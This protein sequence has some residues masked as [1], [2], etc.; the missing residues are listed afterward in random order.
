MPNRNGAA[1][2]S[3]HVLYAS[4][5]Y[6]WTFVAEMICIIEWNYEEHQEN[7]VKSVRKLLL[8]PRKILLGHVDVV[9]V[10]SCSA[11]IKCYYVKKFDVIG[12]RVVFL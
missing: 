5:V 9:K 3:N 11:V 8:R 7:N 2:F 4:F 6:P 1:A 12:V 10:I